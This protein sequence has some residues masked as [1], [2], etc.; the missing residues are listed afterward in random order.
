MITTVHPDYWTHY[1]YWA[2]YRLAYEGGRDFVD[3]Y[4]EYYSDYETATDYEKRK[5]MTYCPAH[6]KAAIQ[7]IK[8]RLLQ[9]FASIRRQGGKNYNAAMATN[10]DREGNSMLAFLSQILDELLVVGKVGVMVDRPQTLGRRNNETSPYLYVYKA[11]DILSWNYDE[12]HQLS[13]VLLHEYQ[14]A[15]KDGLPIGVESV[16]RHIHWVDG[17]VQVDLLN[18]STKVEET[19]QLD[20]DVFPFVMVDLPSSLMV[21]VADYQIALLNMASNDV[22]FLMRAMHPLYVE[23]DNWSHEF[24]RHLR[25]SGDAGEAKVA[26]EELVKTGPLSGRKY[27]PQMERPSFIN[28]SAEP[29][30]ASMAKQKEM[31]AELRSLVHLAVEALGDSPSLESGL[32]YVGQKLETMERRIGRVWAA[33]ERS[34]VP[35]IQYPAQ[36]NAVREET[37]IQRA[38]D[39]QELISATPSLQY[40]KA[41]AKHI[42]DTLLPLADRSGMYREIDASPVVVV[43]AEQL[44]NDSEMGLVSADLASKLRHYPAGE[45]AKAAKDHAERAA[46]IVTAQISAKEEKRISQ[47][48]ETDPE[49][50]KRV[51]S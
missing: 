26:K 8:D 10:V 35:E 27:A 13:N 45:V 40:Q 17:K 37:R 31:V 9:H 34:E 43:D 12:H 14:Y 22:M 11:E 32:M 48:P 25:P 41:I 36:Y 50:V 20:I 15:L 16:Y 47:S 5:K 30:T 2:R 44:R 18:Q 42:V 6:A 3:E 28:P 7:E 21:D 39:L 23:Q 4:L 33:Y 24:N 19:Y 1:F 29:L 51:R 46:R 38:K 49:G